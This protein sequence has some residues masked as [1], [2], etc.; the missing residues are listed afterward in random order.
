MIV[1]REEA[2]KASMTTITKL[3][4]TDWPYTEVVTATLKVQKYISSKIT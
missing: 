4:V 2:K 3:K 1:S